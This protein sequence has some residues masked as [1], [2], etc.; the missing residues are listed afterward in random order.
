[1]GNIIFYISGHGYGHATRSI[2]LI[3]TLMQK[4]RDLF[5]HIK[6]NAPRWLFDLNLKGNYTLHHLKTDIGTVQNTSFYIDK[7]ETLNQW[8]MF[9]KNK[10]GVLQEEIEFA[11]RINARLII[12]DIP[13]LAFDIAESVGIPG[14]A[15]ANFSWDW[16]L[17]DYV[18]DFPE[19]SDLV[20][21]IKGSYK[22]AALLLRLPFYG[23]LSVFPKI[24]DIPLIAR[25]AD[26][27]K[28]EVWQ[29][30]RVNRY[31]HQVLALVALRAS[32]LRSVNLDKLE[33]CEGFLFI[34]F[35][36]QTSFKTGINLPPDFIRFPDL[37]NASDLV[38]S[39]PGYGIVSEIIANQTPLLYTSREDFAEY[40]ILVQGLEQYAG[41]QFLPQ[42]DFFEGNWCEHIKRLVK[43]NAEWKTIPVNGANVAAEEILF[44]L[45]KSI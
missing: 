6:T 20:E 23:D 41:S 38:I 11:K 9:L 29:L 32:D 36:L 12:G 45:S 1:M 43:R 30:L 35:G 37:V 16:I 15:L 21:E 40:P 5:F 33:Q 19:F 4:S 25:K 22:K 3:R 27:S 17:N 24:K 31:R 34:T 7:I 2:E 39:K 28:E 26:K 42:K 10:S 18:K 13:P 14:V 44:L 8:T